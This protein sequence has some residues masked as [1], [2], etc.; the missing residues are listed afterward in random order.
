MTGENA[1]IHTILSQ[2]N[3]FSLCMKDKIMTFF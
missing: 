3:E 1:V 2:Q